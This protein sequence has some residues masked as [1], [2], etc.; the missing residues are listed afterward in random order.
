MKSKVLRNKWVF[1]GELNFGHIL[2]LL[3]LMVAFISWVM[4]LK[5]QLKEQIDINA[6]QMREIQTIGNSLE[7]QAKKIEDLRVVCAELQVQFEKVGERIT[8]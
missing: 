1:N 5:Y 8:R 7:K 6:E 2:A 4:M 3:T